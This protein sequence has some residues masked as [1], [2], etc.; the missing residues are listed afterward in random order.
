MEVK[1]T[2]Y[3]FEGLSSTLAVL[4]GE[5][6]DTLVAKGKKRMG[7]EDVADSPQISELIRRTRE[8]QTMAD[9]ISKGRKG[10]EELTQAIGAEVKKTLSAAGIV[11]RT[12]LARLER[13]IDEIERTLEKGE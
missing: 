11:T 1:E 12:D 3:F 4:S 9:L 2:K 13:R 7:Q 5:L 6:Y 8:Q 10:Q